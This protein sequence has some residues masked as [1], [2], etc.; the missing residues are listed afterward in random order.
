MERPSREGSAPHNDWPAALTPREIKFTGRTGG[1]MFSGIGAEDRPNTDY[2]D[3]GPSPHIDSDSPRTSTRTSE[4]S[5][6]GE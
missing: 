2:G 6:S 4:T 5:S 3:V 1:E